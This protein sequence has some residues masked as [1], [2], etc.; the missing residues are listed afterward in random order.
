MLQRSPASTLFRPKGTDA[1]NPLA[2]RVIALC[3]FRSVGSGFI[4]MSLTSLA[5]TVARGESISDLLEARRYVVALC[6]SGI[7]RYNH[8]SE[9]GE[10]VWAG[11]AIIN[12]IEGGEPLFVPR[13]DVSKSKGKSSREKPAME[14]KSGDES[15]SR[16]G[17][18]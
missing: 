10:I 13:T 14:N 16:G 18:L 1:I 12:L 6:Q 11:P 9:L 17:N 4:A 15:G 8:R 5:L 3:G 2:M 7:L